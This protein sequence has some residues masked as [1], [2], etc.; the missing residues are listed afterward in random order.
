[1]KLRSDQEGRERAEGSNVTEECAMGEASAAVGKR[2]RRM[3]GAKL[4]SGD[5]QVSKI[6]EGV[7]GSRH[8]DEDGKGK[9]KREGKRSKEDVDGRKGRNGKGREK[10]NV[11]GD[12][13][14]GVGSDAILGTV[15]RPVL[16]Y[17]EMAMERHLTLALIQAWD[18]R[19][20]AFRIASREVRFTVFDVALFTG[21]PGTGKKVELD[22]EEV[23]TEVGDMVRA[24]MGEWERKEMA[25][26]V[27]RRSGKKRRFLKH[28]VNVMM[29]LCDENAQEDRVGIWLRLYAFIV[30]SGVLF[31]RTPYG[32]A[33]SLLRYVDDVEGMGQYA[34]AEAVWQVVVDFIEDTQRKLCR[35]PLSEVQLN[36]L[37]LLIQV[38]FYEHTTIFSNQD[39]EQYPRLASWRKVDHGGMYDVTELLEEPKQ[40]ES[41]GRCR[42]LEIVRAECVS[43]VEK[44]RHLVVLVK[45]LKMLGIIFG[46]AKGRVA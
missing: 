22:R 14:V 42:D 28:Y 37:C 29:E 35:G 33:W 45:S 17:G 40:S 43:L 15:L 10:G 12:G 31:P 41:K 21:L 11:A 25:R 18:R 19:R 1:M 32:A 36:G 7:S 27:P 46:K 16:E 9:G 34:W 44:K 3:S 30:L 6:G 2:K 8:T 5:A 38:W 4:S 23:S 20:K 26:R 39:G 24:R 13:R